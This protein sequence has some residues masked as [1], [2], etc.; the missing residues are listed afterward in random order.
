MKIKWKIVL[1]SVGI[2][3]TLTL[4]ILIFTRSEVNNLFFEENNEELQNYSN[5]GLQILNKAY[6]G[7]WEIIDGKLYKGMVQINENYNIIDE[8]TKG[9][10]VLV[11]VF[12]NDT[13]VATTVKDGNG[14]RVIGTRASEE[15]IKKVLSEGKDYSGTADILGKSAQTYYIPIKDSTGATIGMW[16]VGTYT[17]TISEKMNHTM[18]MILVLAGVL[19]LIASI[20]SYF[21]G[22]T[23]AKGIKLI[24]G[25]LLLMEKGEFNFEF[26]KNF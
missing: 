11:T 1:A 12:Q 8:F 14:E 15:V 19:L 26:E 7:D 4:S 23:I 18:I 6:N 25:R 17:D 16:F 22:H 9:T 20:V 3:L 10:K 5:M 13:R 21:L 24:Q 2:I